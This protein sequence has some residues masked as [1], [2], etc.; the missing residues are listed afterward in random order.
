MT[1][2]ICYGCEKRGHKKNKCPRLGTLIPVFPICGKEHLASCCEYAQQHVWGGRSGQ[3]QGPAQQTNTGI[4]TP[5]L[6]AWRKDKGEVYKVCKSG[7]YQVSGASQFS[8]LRPHCV[9]CG[10]C[11]PRICRYGTNVCYKCG[12]SG[13]LQRDC[14]S[15]RQIMG[16]GAAQPASSTAT[17]SIAPLGH[18]AVGG[19]IQSPIGPNRFYAFSYMV[20]GMLT[21]QSC[22]KYALIDSGS[23]LSYVNP[24]IVVGFGIESGQPYDPFC[25]S[26][27]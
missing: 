15:S 22:D 20:T 14:H 2:E 26:T 9:K 13:H 23:A 25:V 6:E 19:S 24:Y 1:L 7:E 17:S 3:F 4:G 10:K 27:L 11:H 12:V 5:A 21:F 8:G 18:G 16:R